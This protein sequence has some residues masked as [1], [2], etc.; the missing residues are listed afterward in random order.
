MPAKLNHHTATVIFLGY[1]A[2]PK[3]ISYFDTGTAKI[4]SATQVVFDEASHLVPSDKLSQAAIALQQSG[5]VTED[6]YENILC[7]QCSDTSAIVF[8]ITDLDIFPNTAEL[9]DTGLKVALPHGTYIQVQGRSG[10]AHP[11]YRGTL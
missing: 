2:T 5:Y 4:K 3:N 10:L 6:D 7:I 1:S 8:S 9:L 11:D